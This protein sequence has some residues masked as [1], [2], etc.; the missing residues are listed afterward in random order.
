MHS[1]SVVFGSR[2]DD[3]AAE[4]IRRINRLEETVLCF[5]YRLPDTESAKNWVMELDFIDLIEGPLNEIERMASIAPSESARSYLL[6]II[7][8]RSAMQREGS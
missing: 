2:V 5:P 4:R 7:S 1:E 8:A 6:G 3:S